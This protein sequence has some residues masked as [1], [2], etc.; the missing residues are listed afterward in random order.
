M[1]ENANII[2]YAILPSL[3]AAKGMTTPLT[4]GSNTLFCDKNETIFSNPGHRFVTMTH[5]LS[6]FITVFALASCASFALSDNLP[7]LE[8][9]PSTF[10]ARVIE[11]RVDI[12]WK[13]EKHS[14]EAVINIDD[15]KLSF[16]FMTFGARVL[17]FNYD[18]ESIH[19]TFLATTSLPEKRIVN[20]FLLVYSHRSDL[21]NALPISCVVDDQLINKHI[22]KQR[23]ISCDNRALA[24]IEYTHHDDQRS[25]IQ[26]TH[27]TLH[28]QL[29]LNHHKLS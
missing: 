8:I 24:S 20:D 10:G 27:H 29:T 12:A 2:S 9:P 22:L 6:L 26:F 17:S 1:K 13:N 23:L 4:C 11:Q 16:I 3:A 15:E 18:G 19:T 21:Q 25:T 5:F 28:Y 7:L 14:L